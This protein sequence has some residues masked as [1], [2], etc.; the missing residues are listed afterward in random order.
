MTDDKKTDGFELEGENIH[1]DVEKS[2]S[3]Y[4]N[5][6]KVLSAQNP[7]SNEHD[8]M[9]FVIVHHVMELW[10]KQVLHE[11]TAARGFIDANNLEPSLKMFSRIDR[12]LKQMTGVWDVLATMTPVD[13]LKFRDGLGKSSGFQSVQFR[14]I[15]FILG[16]KSK[17]LVKVHESNPVAFAAV[18]GALNSATL[19]DTVLGL[20]KKRGF[21]ISP[22]VLNRDVTE[23]YQAN[24]SVK[25]AWL[26]IYSDTEKYWDLYALAEKLMD[27]EHGFQIW[28]YNHLKT[29]ERI[30]GG[31]MG[32]GGSSGIP[33]LAK[34][35]EAKLFP[36]LLSVR[37]E[38]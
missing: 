15:E 29:V 5:L 19:Y 7:Q 33:Y 23:N 37:T 27:F 38:L 2:Y 30:I 4:L 10:M 6:D 17:G 25:A 26:A 18:N 35:L 1:W 32:T 20:L 9:L 28:R 11:L 13:Y 14:V 22:D 34:G 36:E 16:N 24:D 12:V 8:E 3:Q 21:D 31:K